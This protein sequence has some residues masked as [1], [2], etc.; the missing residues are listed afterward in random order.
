MVWHNLSNALD[1]GHGLSYSLALL[2][3]IHVCAD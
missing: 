1:R 3:E 2:G